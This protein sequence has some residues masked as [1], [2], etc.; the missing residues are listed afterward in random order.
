MWYYHLTIQKPG[1]MHNY[2]KDILYHILVVVFSTS[3]TH[4][5]SSGKQ[6]LI[7]FSSGPK[8]SASKDKNGHLSVVSVY[9]SDIRH[10]MHH[11]LHSK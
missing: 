2:L 7:E 5:L 11:T 8:Y 9:K 3:I 4:Q 1:I 6:G 10:R